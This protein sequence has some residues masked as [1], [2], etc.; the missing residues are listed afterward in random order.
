MVVVLV[1]LG[2]VK[3]AHGQRKE[4]TAFVLSALYIVF[5]LVGAAVAVFP[6]VLSARNPAYSRTIYNAAA[7]EYGLKIGL[8]WWSLGAVLAAVYFTFL[9]RMFKGKVQVEGE[10]Y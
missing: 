5:M 3:W 7:A 9:F 4:K 6:N 2:G 1:L 10:G 8:I